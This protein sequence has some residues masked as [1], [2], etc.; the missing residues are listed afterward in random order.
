M[1][2]KNVFFVFVMVLLV[3]SIAINAAET[4]KEIFTISTK[5]PEIDGTITKDEYPIVI[6]LKK[7]K[8]YLSRT[9]KML[10]FAIAAE[11]N[12]W[13]ALGFNSNVMDKARMVL[14]YVKDGKQEVTEQIG[15]GHKHKDAETKILTQSVLTEDK[16]TTI[17]EGAMEINSILTKDQK[18]LDIIAAIG[19]SD[20]FTSIH[21]FRK[22]YSI[23]LQ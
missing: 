8:V 2:K 1:E 11:S 7:V 4:K 14:G 12:G 5:L 6:D 9:D 22:A 13:V 18:T 23:D 16:T 21:S 10:S 20:N 3:F 19:S 15:A 17:F